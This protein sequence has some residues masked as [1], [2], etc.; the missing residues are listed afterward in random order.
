[1]TR[2]IARVPGENFDCDRVTP[3]CEVCNLNEYACL[4]EIEVW[5]EVKNPMSMEQVQAAFAKLFPTSLV[6]VEELGP[7]RIAA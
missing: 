3:N 1:M 2:P 5:P 7:G 6:E 4:C